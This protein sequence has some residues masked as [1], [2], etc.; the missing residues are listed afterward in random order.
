MDR[1]SSMTKTFIDAETEYGVA[2]PEHI[3]AA[4]E[5]P[6]LTGMQRQGDVIVLPT[7]KGKV[8]GLE[9]IPAEG[10]AVVRGEAGGNTHLLIG[11]GRFAARASRAGADLGTL[12]VEPGEAT[13]L[14]H[15][16]HGYQGI[17]PGTYIVRR[18]RVMEDEIALV[19][20]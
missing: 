1:R 10:I 15:P 16:E 9:P 8:A 20:D 13:Y 14:A 6:V 11:S 7:R 4:A 3:E 2:L 17:G 18:Q 12:V 19:R 5:I